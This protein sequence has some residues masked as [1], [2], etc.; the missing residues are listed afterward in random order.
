MYLLVSRSL[1]TLSNSVG[2]SYTS[3]FTYNFMG[4]YLVKV[5]LIASLCSG[6][7]QATY[8]PIPIS[9]SLFLGGGVN[10]EFFISIVHCSIL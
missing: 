9:G 1:I 6:V 3:Y 10:P 5:F 2:D 7:C 8:L 4:D